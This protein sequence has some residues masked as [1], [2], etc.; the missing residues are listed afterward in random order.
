[1]NSFMELAKERYSM[2][3]F[4][5][6]VVEKEKL[7]QILEAGRIAPTA[8]NGQPQRIKIIT[9]QEDIAKMDEC[10]RSRFGSTTILLVC[11]DKTVSWQRQYDDALSGQV[12][13]SI[14]TTH[15]MLMATELGL[16]TCWVMHFDPAKTIELFELPENIVPVAYLP[17]GYPSET[18]APTDRHNDR[19]PIE[20]FLF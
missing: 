7:D 16:G 19:F 12:D 3:S 5:E 1:M 4:S 17:M 18:A 20:N 10:T 2:R 9:S 14:I 13:A 15:M 6:Q 8:R 11:Y